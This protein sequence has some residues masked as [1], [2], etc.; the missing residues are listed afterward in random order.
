MVADV[1]VCNSPPPLC[2][3]ERNYDKHMTQKIVCVRERER[4][5]FQINI[6]IDFMLN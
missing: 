5:S 3:A 2:N 6:V 1:W 4:E